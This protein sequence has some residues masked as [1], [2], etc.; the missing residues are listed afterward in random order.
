MWAISL[1]GNMAGSVA[2][3][4]ALGTYVFT[5]DP[6]QSWVVSLAVKKTSMPFDEVSAT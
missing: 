1:A 4:G 5:S 3:A 2:I 6:W